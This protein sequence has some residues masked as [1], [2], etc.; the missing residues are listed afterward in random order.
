MSK[1]STL[2]KKAL[3]DAKFQAHDGAKGASEVRG[4]S[5]AAGVQVSEA[6]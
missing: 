1:M 4:V 2:D 6:L 5:H 3:S